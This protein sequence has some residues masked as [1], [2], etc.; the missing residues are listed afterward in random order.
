[1]ENIED[2]GRLMD[3]SPLWRLRTPLRRWQ[4][5]ALAEWSRSRKGVIRVV[6]GAG[7]TVLALACMAQQHEHD[8]GCRYLILVP[9]VALLDQWAVELN[10]TLG[11]PQEHIALHGGGFRG[12]VDRPVNVAVLNT[13]RVLT[14]ELTRTGTW[15]VI[16]DECHRIAPPENRQALPDS[17]ASTLGLSATPERSHDPWFEEY[18]VPVL[19]PVIFQYGYSEALRDSVIVPFSLHNIRIPI[20]DEEESEIHNLTGR[21]GRLL[22]AGRSMTD[23]QVRRLLLQR[24]RKIRELKSR[25][26]TTVSLIERHPGTRVL[27]FHE[28]IAAADTI[29]QISK[30][31]GHS[32]AAYHSKL[33][34]VTRQKNLFL[35][36]RGL[37]RVL[38]TCRALDEG[39]NVP[40]TGVGVIAAATLSI[41]QRI[42]R[43]GRILRPASG[44]AQALVYTL[45]GTDLERDLLAREAGQ[46]E[47]VANVKWYRAESQ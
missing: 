14:R 34:S 3:I 33:G 26:A 10:Q 35:F 13:A 39:L 38:V 7:K 20:E 18:V 16:V 31:R 6:T 19:G 27:I 1:V 9:T 25:I 45:Y 44:K 22:G 24:A 15:F 12:Q 23:V 29:T 42:Q 30:E 36:R 4:S 5:E 41:R 37:L 11:V 28:S 40:E 47:G 32:V 17:P 8:P 43:M 2:S 21:V 46:L